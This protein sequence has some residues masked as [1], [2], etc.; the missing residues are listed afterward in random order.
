MKK[1]LVSRAIFPDVLERL[2][3]YFEVESNQEDRIFT[4]DELVGKVADKDGIFVAGDRID[5]TVLAA[6]P[7][8]RVVSNMAVG[9]NNFDMKAFDQASVLGTNT[10]D[11]LNETPTD[12]G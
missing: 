6:A 1:I 10:P 4:R 8:L 7:R 5:E 11:V 9:Y 3:R 2:A 12:L